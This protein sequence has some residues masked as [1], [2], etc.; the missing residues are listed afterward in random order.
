M[1]V[2]K[3]ILSQ[4]D[5]IFTRNV[6]H[7]LEKIFFYL[8]YESYLK[9]IGV[10]TIWKNMLLS[11]LFKKR[12]KIMYLPEIL[13]DEEKLRNASFIGDSDAVNKLISYGLVDVNSENARGMT[14]LLFALLGPDEVIKM[15]L[16][17]GA[18][19]NKKGKH[20]QTPLFQACRNQVYPS[21]VRLL[22]CKGADPNTQDFR[23]CTPLHYSAYDGRETIVKILLYGGALPD[24]KN[25]EDETPLRI[26]AGRG[27]KYVFEIMRRFLSR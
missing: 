12:A 18:D 8:D 1:D 15:L 16:D 20:G 11:D 26:A 24:L 7:I 13:R 22:L 6:P 9:C 10:S 27:R 17:G 25:N 2:E 4:F 23:G 14:P 19:P 5:A 21:I 3:R